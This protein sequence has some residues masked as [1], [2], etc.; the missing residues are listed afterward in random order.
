[1]RSTTTSGQMMNADRLPK[2]ARHVLTATTHTTSALDN[3]CEP[4]GFTIAFAPRHE[5]LN[6]RVVPI[7]TR[8]QVLP[9]EPRR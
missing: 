1:M 7:C 3:S 2:Q 8:T 4:L 6:V 5:R 9:P